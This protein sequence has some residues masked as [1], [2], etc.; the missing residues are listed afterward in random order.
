[1]TQEEFN[2]KYPN[3]N[4]QNP[5]ECLRHNGSNATW[6]GEKL[7]NPS[8]MKKAKEEYAQFKKDKQA[9][10]AGKQSKAQDKQK[11][12]PL[13]SWH[14]KVAK[15]D[16]TDEQK[17][18]LDYG[19][20]QRHACVLEKDGKIQ[21]SKD[22]D[23]AK[24]AESKGWKNLGSLTDIVDKGK[25]PESK[26]VDKPETKQIKSSTSSLVPTTKDEI[27]KLVASGKSKD[28]IMKLA[29][30]AGV[31]WKEHDH[32]GINWM[33]CCM[34]MTGT[35]TTGNKVN[36]PVTSAPKQDSSAGE[37]GSARPLKDYE[38]SSLKDGNTY[39]FVHLLLELYPKQ[40]K[41]EGIDLHKVVNNYKS[42]VEYDKDSETYTLYTKKGKVFFDTNMKCTGSKDW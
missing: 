32:A 8:V 39:S 26:S 34:A 37:K 14:D 27:Q 30:E 9:L 17:K 29:K 36:K 4:M 1:M 16:F 42:L 5:E 10:E 40:C 25:L 28:D 23:E 35:N 12:D 41:K 11:D 19:V 20:S 22:W 38:K 3:G 13:K 2:K 21:T 6:H 15:G 7:Q 18:Q 31:T 24:Y 33:R